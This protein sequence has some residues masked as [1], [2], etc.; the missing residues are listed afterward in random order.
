MSRPYSLADS[1]IT[2]YE[3]VGPVIGTW[4]TVFDGREAAGEGTRRGEAGD[5]GYLYGG[6]RIEPGRILSGLISCNYMAHMLAPPLIILP[7]TC[8]TGVDKGLV[9]RVST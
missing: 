1:G 8:P 7:Q 2:E 4:D 9:R 5:K 6:P 3:L